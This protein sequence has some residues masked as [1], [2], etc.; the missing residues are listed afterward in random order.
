MAKVVLRSSVVIFTEI[1]ID[2]NYNK[3]DLIKVFDGLEDAD[4][5]CDIFSKNST[6]SVVTY[7]D[8]P[9]RAIGTVTDI[10]IKI[11]SQEIM[12]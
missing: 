8:K 10:E 12:D 3:E 4:L 7:D 11:N 2:D 9:D 5:D 1:E 6:V